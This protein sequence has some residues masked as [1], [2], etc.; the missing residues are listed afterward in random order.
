M[1]LE[2]KLIWLYCYICEC[3][4]SELHSH[5]QRF[6]NNS[7]PPAFTDC[8]LL[9]CYI[10]AIAEERKTTVKGAY[11]YTKK[12]WQS[13]FPQI[14]S[15]KR[16]DRRLNRLC[17]VFPFLVQQILQQ[18]DLQGVSLR[19]SLGDSMPIMLASSK[20]SNMAKV[21]QQFCNKGYC[22]SKG[23][24]YYG[25]KLH[26]LA[27]EKKGS[28]PLPEL[29]QITPASEHD[30][31]AIRPV[32]EKLANRNFFLDKAYC[33]EE[34]AKDLQNKINSQLFT[35]IK[36]KKGQKYFKGGE[37][38]YSTAVSRVRQPIESFFIW[39]DEKTGIQ[40]ASKVRSYKGLIVHVFGKLA[41]AMAILIFKVFN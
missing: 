36:K 2:D 14:P 40:I 16:F 37:P 39:I 11:D 32:L 3:Y 22:S 21:A 26:A 24:F 6:S 38:T 29:L 7:N 8:E 4:V 13:W 33:D 1:K 20:R 12:Y 19:N 23:C 5:C 28:L 34:L 17:S 31:T 35:P 15:Y 9:T 27:F 30:L 41:A 25:V 18:A 10:F